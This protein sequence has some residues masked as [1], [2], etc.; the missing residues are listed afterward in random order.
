[1]RALVVVEEWALPSATQ[2]AGQVHLASSM[3]HW[4]VKPNRAALRSGADS[5]RCKARKTLGSEDWSGMRLREQAS[6]LPSLN[7]MSANCAVAEA[8]TA[9]S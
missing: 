5:R 3:H 2:A 9:I 1:M 7:R 6:A 8:L 4:A